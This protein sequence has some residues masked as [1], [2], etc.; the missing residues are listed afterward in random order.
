MRVRC[1]WTVDFGVEEEEGTGVLEGWH[2]FEEVGFAD[3]GELVDARV[4]EE[5]LEAWYAGFDQRLEVVLS[6]PRTSD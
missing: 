1:G 2:G 6:M 4:D 5:A 3:A